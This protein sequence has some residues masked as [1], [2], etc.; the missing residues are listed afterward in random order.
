M[1]CSS[2]DLKRDSSRALFVFV[3]CRALICR[4]LW[5]QQQRQQLLLAARTLKVTSSETY[6]T[7]AACFCRR[8][9]SD[10]S[11]FQ[12]SWYFTTLSVQQFYHLPRREFF[13]F[14]CLDLVSNVSRHIWQQ[15]FWLSTPSFLKWN[16]THAPVDLQHLHA[17]FTSF[18]VI[19]WPP[20]K[21]N[22]YDWKWEGCIKFIHRIIY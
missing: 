20:I 12:R 16:N 6:I 18:S 10:C 2:T 14:K 15:G 21:I 8:A 3:V 7:A 1:R 5:I 19:Y 22:V 9:T 13:Y 17:R 11:L 4:L